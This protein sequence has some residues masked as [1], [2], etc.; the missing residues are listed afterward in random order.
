MN[1]CRSSTSDD[2]LEPEGVNIEHLCPFKIP[3]RKD[4]GL[5]R[6][7]LI[8]IE[9]LVANEANIKLVLVSMHD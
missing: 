2:R 5:N 3:R 9:K 4:F 8:C 1:V 6:K 7:I